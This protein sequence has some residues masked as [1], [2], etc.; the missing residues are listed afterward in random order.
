[1]LCVTDLWKIRMK[2]GTSKA[3]PPIPLADPRLFMRAT[4]MVPMIS[5]RE[6]GKRSFVTQI[7]SMQVWREPHWAFEVQD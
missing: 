7:L 2:Y 1:M 5:R 6:R 3:P 4:E